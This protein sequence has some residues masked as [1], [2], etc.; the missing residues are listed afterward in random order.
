[1]R[2]AVR[3]TLAALS[4]SLRE[5]TADGIVASTSANLRSWGEK[6]VIAFAPDKAVSVTSKCALATQRLDW[7]TNKTNVGTFLTELRQHV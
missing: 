4:W 7:G 5:E 1:L 6:V 2:E 3:E